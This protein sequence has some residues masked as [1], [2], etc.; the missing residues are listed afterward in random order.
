V[1]DSRGETYRTTEKV[2]KS[3][4]EPVLTIKY[5][6]TPTKMLK[7]GAMMKAVL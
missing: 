5:C 3:F 2:T 4:L 6:I 1:K 7:S